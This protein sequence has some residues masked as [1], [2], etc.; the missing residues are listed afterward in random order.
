[1]RLTLCVPNLLLISL[2]FRYT[3]NDLT[4]LELIWWN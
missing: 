3:G 2:R 4:P 1:M